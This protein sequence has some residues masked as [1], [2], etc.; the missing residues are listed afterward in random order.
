[1][2]CRFLQ[3]NSRDILQINMT[4]EFESPRHFFMCVYASIL[5]RILTIPKDPNGVPLCESVLDFFQKHSKSFL[6]CL[7]CYHTL[8]QNSGAIIIYAKKEIQEVQEHRLHEDSLEVEV[9]T[10]ILCG[11]SLEDL[12]TD[13]ERTWIRPNYRFFRTWDLTEKEQ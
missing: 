9:D 2:E 6:D 7:T 13:R 8:P 3:G 11:I 10:I 1:M 12:E 4:N 5:K